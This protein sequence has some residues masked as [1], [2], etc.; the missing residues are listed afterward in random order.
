LAAYS[1]R[2][3]FLE[4][5][6][7]AFDLDQAPMQIFETLIALR[8]GGVQ[9]LQAEQAANV[10]EDILTLVFKRMADHGG[11]IIDRQ[12]GRASPDAVQ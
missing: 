12:A 6:N 11:N 1:S 7:F 2:A 5:A 4:R 10:S 8:G 3:A 9:L